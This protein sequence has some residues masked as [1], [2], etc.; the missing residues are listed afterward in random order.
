MQKAKWLIAGLLLTMCFLLGIALFLP[1]K[2]TVSKSIIINAPSPIVTRQIVDFENWKNWYPGF[3]DNEISIFITRN[4]N[5]SLIQSAQLHDNRGHEIIFNIRHQPTDTINVELET[6]RRELINYQF[7]TVSN[8]KG[9]TQ[10]VW[11]INTD[12]GW[13]P[14]KKIQGVIMD[15][16]TGQEYILALQNLKKVAEQNA[17][18]N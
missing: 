9:Q 11:N 4:K 5:D 3:M 7:I 2:V 16:M 1:S 8:N 13:Y 12:L 17:R 15:K 18:I 10:I 14:W 6:N